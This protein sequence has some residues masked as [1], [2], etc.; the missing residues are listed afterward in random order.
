MKKKHAIR[1]IK[2]LITAPTTNDDV[3]EASENTEETGCIS[4]PIDE[5]SDDS[6]SESELERELDDLFFQVDQ[7]L[8]IILWWISTPTQLL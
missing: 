1:G 2:K 7:L 6:E 5:E 3:E 4:E 8:M